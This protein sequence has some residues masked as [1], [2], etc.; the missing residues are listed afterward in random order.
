MNLSILGQGYAASNIRA[1]LVGADSHTNASEQYA[2][3]DAMT[4][5]SGDATIL[6]CFPKALQD[7]IGAKALSGVTAASSGTGMT[8]DSV[9][10]DGVADKL[11]LFSHGEMTD[12]V[13]PSAG[14]N[15][16]TKYD[17]VRSSGWWYWTRS[18]YTTSRPGIV[19]NNGVLSSLA[20]KYTNGLVA[21]GFTLA[22]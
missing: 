19:S 22:R 12:A 18:P 7:A 14:F 6:S 1:A 21:P 15:N 16:G 8:Y 4:R 11:W 9:S 20:T 5:Y 17:A 13:Y 10:N 3:A 2:G